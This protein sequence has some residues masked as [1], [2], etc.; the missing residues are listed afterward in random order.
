MAE[1]DAYYFKHDSNAHTDFK[2]RRLLKRYGW[3]GYGWWWLLIEI[4]RDQS[5][6]SLDYAEDTFDILSAEMACSIEEAQQFIDYLLEIK[7]LQ[8]NG[9]DNLFS[10][11]LNSDMKVKDD[12][13]GQAR[14]AALRRWHPEKHKQRKAH[15]SYD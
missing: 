14:E 6:Y 10:T 5:S 2:V 8:R 15:E 1:K 13:Q 12:I 4:L 11:R 3:Q 9:H 7:L